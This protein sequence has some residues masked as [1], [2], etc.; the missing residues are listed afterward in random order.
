[1]HIWSA[2][3]SAKGQSKGNREACVRSA[4]RIDKV[5]RSFPAYRLLLV[6][7]KTNKLCIG[8]SLIILIES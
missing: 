5:G 3:L 4:G 7:F 8:E 2:S 6:P 1:M